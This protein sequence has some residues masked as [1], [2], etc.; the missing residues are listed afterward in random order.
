VNF[1]EEKPDVQANPTK[2]ALREEKPDVQANPTRS[3]A[4]VEER[5]PVVQSGAANVAPFAKE[6][7][8][9]AMQSHGPQAA[10]A[11]AEEKAAAAQPTGTKVM[12]ANEKPASTQANG[13]KFAPAAQAPAGEI[14]APDVF[15]RMSK[16]LAEVAGV[17]SPLA[18]LIVREHV[19]GLG[20]SIEKF[21]KSRLPELLDSLV[22]EIL[23]EKRQV[24]FRKR[25]VRCQLP[26]TNGQP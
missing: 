23:D 2:S 10:P 24:D 12:V 13:V 25:L 6:Q 22:R 26:A 18:T 19:E 14:F 21:P 15:E 8:P 20:E 1:R 3:A 11:V 17:M 16:E 4:P 5:S 9:V 7:K